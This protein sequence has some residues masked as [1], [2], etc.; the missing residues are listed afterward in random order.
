MSDSRTI[1]K[2]IGSEYGKDYAFLRTIGLKYIE[3]LANKLWTD[4]NT[5]DPGVTMLEMLCYAITDL[6]YRI[7]MPVED[8][9]AQPKDNLRHMHEQFLSA[10]RALPSFPVS[11]DDYRQLFVRIEG[12]RNCWLTSADRWIIAKF[13]NLP[14]EGRPQLQYKVPGKVT[15]PTEEREFRLQGLN[16]ILLDYDEAAF[17][18]DEDKKKDKTTQQQLIAE[19]KKGIRQNVLEIYQRYRNLCEDIDT[20]REVPL[21]GVVICGDIDIAANADPEQVWARIVFNIDRYLAPDIPFYSLQEMQEMGKTTDQIFEGPVFS[22]T[23]QYPFA[24]PGNPF[25]KKGFIRHE[26]LENSE[27]RTEVRLSDIIR[28]IMNTEGVRLVKDIGFGLCD[29]DETNIDKVRQA[30]AGDRW[31]LCIVPGHK[32]V[33]CTD[34]SVLNL[35]KGFMPIELKMEEA[36]G[37]LDRLRDERH[38]K[39]QAKLTEDM[40]MP[41]GKYRSIEEYQTFQNDFP[42]TYGIGRAGLPDGA[43]TRRKAQAKQLKGYLLFFEQVLANYF[44]QLANVSVLFAADNSIPRTYF[45]G[46]VAGLTDVKEIFTNDG[47]WKNEIET[48]LLS[49]GLDPY[50]TRKNMFLDHLLARFAEQ[51]N[52]YVFLMHRLYAQDAERIIIRQKVNYLK[53][54]DNM[55]TCRG[56]G[57]DY[58]NPLS[59]LQMLT[60]IPGMEKRISRLLGFNHYQRL[61]LSNLSY[62]VIATGMVNVEINGVVTAVQGY[63]WVIRQGGEIILESI[64]TAFVK[65]VEAYE[66]LG[67]ASL[68]GC[69]R[70]YYRPELNAD[71][72]T[73]NFTLVNTSGVAMAG[74]PKQYPLTE[75]ELPEGPF[76]QLETAIAGI[77]RYLLEDFRLEGMYV[78]ENLLLRPDSDIAESKK[79]LFLPVCIEPS[80]SFC[81]PL[82]PYSFRVTVVLPGY[83]MRLRNKYFRQFAE[84]LIRME[85][86]A[87]VL[88][89]ICFVNAEYMQLFEETYGNWLNERRSSEDPCRQASDGTLKALLEVLGKIITIYQEGRLTDCD[90]DTPDKNPIVL[91]SSMLGSLKSDGQPG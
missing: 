10:I 39:M 72:T 5:H 29:C 52:E 14:V 11:C 84:R 4:Y 65:K 57:F 61:P 87:H 42:E 85:T 35:W 69:E 74:H 37:Q 58:Y 91:G 83:S 36:H 41:A 1:Q 79:E 67:L 68:L 23:D 28:I 56:T 34:N 16:T 88:P 26:D 12:V 27:L 17:L 86:P 60:N 47:D 59:S 82:D 20:I 25:V 19:K 66:E 50:I 32:P 77:I 18:S 63:G 54:Y 90:D 71:Q 33:F 62:Q 73:V 45:S 21:S 15:D 49:S 9:L 70:V 31:N 13:K 22:F 38:L 89:R 78:V 2:E 76:A 24:T 81:Q 53:D 7:A 80:G 40:P 51:F 44:A 8:I 55:S 75:N 30:V 46:A 6:G 48:L 64:N 43:S 3:S